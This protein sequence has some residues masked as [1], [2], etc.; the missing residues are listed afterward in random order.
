MFEPL[1]HGLGGPLGGGGGVA[2]AFLHTGRVDE[3]KVHDGR[4]GRAAE[5][6]QHHVLSSV[7]QAAISQ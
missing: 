4:R 3:H 6:R 1:G 7:G 5:H 2:V